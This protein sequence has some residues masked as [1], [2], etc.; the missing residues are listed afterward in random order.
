MESCFGGFFMDSPGYDTLGRLTR[1]G[2]IPGETNLPGY[3][4][5]GIQIF[6]LKIRINQQILNQN[7]KYFNSLVRIRKKTGGQLSRWTVPLS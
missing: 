2:M 3:D 6:G 5:P 1:R 7:L 4:T